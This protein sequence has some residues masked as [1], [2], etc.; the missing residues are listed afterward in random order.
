MSKVWEIYKDGDLWAEKTAAEI[1]SSLKSGEILPTDEV[2]LP[3]SKIRQSVFE[4]DEIFDESILDGI[5]GAEEHLSAPTSSSTGIGSTIKT[6]TKS[7]RRKKAKPKKRE[8][9][10]YFLIN[11]NGKVSGPHPASAILAMFHKG[12]ISTKLRVKKYGEHQSLPISKFVLLCSKAPSR[13][14]K[15]SIKNNELHMNSRK[16]SKASRIMGSRNKVIDKNASLALSFLISTI[17]VFGGAFLF[18]EFNVAAKKPVKQKVKSRVLRQPKLLKKLKKKSDTKL[19][20]SKKASKKA[21]RKSS[22]SKKPSSKVGGRKPAKKVR[23]K[24]RAPAAKRARLRSGSENPMRMS[25]K[26]SLSPIELA[27]RSGPRINEVGPVSFDKG[28]LENCEDLCL[29]IVKDNKG[30][31]MYVRFFK[32]EFYSQLINKSSRVTLIG[33]TKLES[34]RLYMFLQTVR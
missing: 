18:N 32:D 19:K 20:A 28:S 9:A 6:I 29:L 4:V 11:P 23:V 24:P 7:F 1:R 10:A 17:L 31:K 27:T 33:H 34:S 16:L 25:A 26:A 3:L 5:Y 2:A 22:V 8:K 12:L 14:L 15:N 13:S 30:L 21:S